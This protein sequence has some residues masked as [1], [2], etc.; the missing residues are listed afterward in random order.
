MSKKVMFTISSLNYM[1][2]SLN[3]RESF[4]KYNPDWD[5]IIF[6]MDELT[7]PESLKML[8]DLTNNGIDI[9]SFLEVKNLVPHYPIEEMLNRYSVLEVNT[10][11]KPFCI[12]Y[13]M[14]SGYNKVIYIDPD[15]QFY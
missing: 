10:A 5:F 9:R 14:K 12:E 2:Y 13:L 3:V 1:H 8:S 6:M 15:I 4:L 7:S 11:I